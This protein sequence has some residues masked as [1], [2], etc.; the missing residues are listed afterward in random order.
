M[1][2]CYL[3]N[4]TGGIAVESLSVGADDMG[5][6]KAAMA[7]GTGQPEYTSLRLT[8]GSGFENMS[9]NLDQRS[10]LTIVVGLAAKNSFKFLSKWCFV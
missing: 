10:S 3:G 8:A 7:T 1:T 5:Q 2:T 4:C 9:D 6:G